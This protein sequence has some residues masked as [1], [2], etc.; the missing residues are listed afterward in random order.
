MP[1]ADA[2]LVRV[3]A[4]GICNTDLE[5]IRGYS[6]FSG[7]LGHE[8]TGVVE[9]AGPLQ[10]KRVV[11]EI[12]LSCRACQ[13]CKKGLASHCSN[14][15]VLGI[16]GKDGAMADYLTLPPEN[17]HCIPDQVPDH[18]AVFV[19]PLAAALQIIDQVRP[20]PDADVLVMG[21]GKLGL[22]CAMALSLHC[23]NLTLSGKHQ[24]KLAIARK[25]GINTTRRG[26]LDRTFDLVIEASGSRDGLSEALDLV[27]PRG[28]VVLKSTTADP[29]A[30]HLF[31]IVV[32]EIT[33]VGSRCGPFPKALAAL[34]SREINVQPLI[35][36]A[37]PADQAMAAF[38]HAAAPGAL[39]IILDFG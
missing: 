36:A 31:P 22:L 21:D 23:R 30:I 20:A 28:T 32:N 5:I 27:R 19:E 12:N 24:E 18:Q 10:G 17:L 26:T 11:G 35:T 15:T 34:A 7:I 4:C 37:Y 14:R 16:F 3:T 13:L 39:K 33:V 9:S 1:A 2:A 6:G 29:A 38:Q 25:L 8:F